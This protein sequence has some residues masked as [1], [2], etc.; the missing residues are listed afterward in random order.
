[1]R[2]NRSRLH[3][4]D[5]ARTFAV[6]LALLSHSL[7][8]TEVLDRMGAD[9]LYI[10]LHQAVHPKQ[11]TRIATPIFVFMFGFMIEFVYATRARDSGAASIQR[12]LRVRSFQCY[13]RIMPDVLLHSAGWPPVAL[14]VRRVPSLLRKF[15]LREHPP[16]LRRH[17]ALHSAAGAT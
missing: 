8:N 12:R 17:H 4:I 13:F 6:V 5:F 11:F 9:S 2:L 14:R 7:N 1:M 15:P 16:G 10:T 3:F